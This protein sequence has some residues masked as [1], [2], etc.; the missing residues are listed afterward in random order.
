M[1]RKRSRPTV[2]FGAAGW[3]FDALP[4]VTLG[5]DQVTILSPGQ[6]SPVM[7]TTELLREIR[8][9]VTN[10][11][12][13]IGV[14]FFWA[15][16]W[17]AAKAGMLGIGLAI[18]IVPAWFRYMVN[19]LEER[20]NGRSA[21]VP[22]IETFSF[23]DSNWAL[24]PLALIALLIWAE[25][26]LWATGYS[27]FG[28]ALWVVATFIL[29][30]SLGVLA[31]THSP[32]QSLSPIAIFS[33]IRACGAAYFLVP[34]VLILMFAIL[35]IFD[36]LG[37]PPV[38]LQLAASYVFI[39]MFTLTGTVLYE[40]DIAGAV[41]I[42]VQDY[43]QGDDPNAELDKERQRVADHAYGFISRGNRDGGF[44]HIMDWIKSEQDISAAA[45]WFFNEMMSWESKDAALIYG[46]TCFAHFLHH[47]E[48]RR[49][50]KLMSSCLHQDSRWK[51]AT[52]DR[53]HALELAERYG[54]ED[55]VRLLRS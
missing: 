18:I 45:T 28:W 22:S 9:P 41:H 1:R 6:V 17:L 36:R 15:I 50:L 24:T 52:E 3:P 12:I 23:W 33:L 53:Q 32:I 48:D 39:L 40:N 37:V 5:V 4:G 26:V 47:E 42:D 38:V 7:K 49:A 35:A 54:R 16:S 29:P 27:T 43:R 55:L 2:R 31:V 10:A 44:A 21:P 46:Q 20:A 51:P 30:A 13:I 25:I 11:T 34:A 19:L 14:I 8:Y